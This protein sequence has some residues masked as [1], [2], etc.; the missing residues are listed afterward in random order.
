M[1]DF[2]LDIKVII[3]KEIS[4]HF[5]DRKENTRILLLLGLKK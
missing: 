3:I 5:S 2:R 4:S 1:K